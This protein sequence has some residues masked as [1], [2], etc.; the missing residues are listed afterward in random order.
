[1]A[2]QRLLIKLSALTLCLR[3]ALSVPS[4]DLDNRVFNLSGGYGV[5]LDVGTPP[6]KE[7]LMLCITCEPSSSYVVAKDAKVQC[8]QDNSCYPT[9]YPRFD[10]TASSTFKGNGSEDLLI[11][12]GAYDYNTTGTYF[13]DKMSIN[14]QELQGLSLGLAH[15]S[16]VRWG[17]LAMGFSR[18]KPN[19]LGLLPYAKQKGLIAAE[20]FSLW[21][22]GACQLLP[23]HHLTVKLTLS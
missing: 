3:T 21:L 12:S 22:N 14:G 9:T 4:F 18:Q 16:S 10:S 11:F 23:H 8:P 13:T 7:W 20:A 6:Q 19:M 17:A 5:T 2:S 1:M 15:Q